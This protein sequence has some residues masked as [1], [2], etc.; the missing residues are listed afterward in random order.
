MTVILI[1][2]YISLL[3]KR[4]GYFVIPPSHLPARYAGWE[5]ATLVECVHK[6][7]TQAQ[8]LFLFQQSRGVY[9]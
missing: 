3:P 2:K 4:T 6:E 7:F 8:F 5:Y 1:E 9:G